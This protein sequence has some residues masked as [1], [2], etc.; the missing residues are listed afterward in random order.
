MLRM[1]LTEWGLP[2][3]VVADRYDANS[4]TDALDAGGCS[5]GRAGVPGHGM[6]GRLRRCQAVSARGNRRQGQDVAVAVNAGSHQR[7]LVP[8]WTSSAIRSWQRAL[9]AGA[10][11]RHKDDAAAA[12]VIAVSAGMLASGIYGQRDGE[13]VAAVD[14]DPFG[15]LI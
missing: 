13:P 10:G 9:R 14:D 2:D 3:V 12:G 7:V 8:W 1:A 5:A 15:A 6:E 4:F 11:A